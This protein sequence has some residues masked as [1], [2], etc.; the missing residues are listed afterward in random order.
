MTTDTE[1]LMDD[2]RSVV[3]DAE[4]LLHATSGQAGAGLEEA[5]KRAEHSVRA[6]RERL[7]E[8]HGDVTAQARAAARATNRYVHD[9]PWAAVGAAIGVGLVLGVLIARR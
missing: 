7:D 4:K 6:A 1:R 5:R 8:L 2:L 9:N 3:E